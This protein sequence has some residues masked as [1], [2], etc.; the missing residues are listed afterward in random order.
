MADG[1]KKARKPRGAPK[2]IEAYVV[3]NVVD[4]DGNVVHGASVNILVASKRTDDILDTMSD[5]PGSV[6]KKLTINPARGQVA[7]AA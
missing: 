3:Y 4:E 6:Y 5:N 1:E 7:A 2:P